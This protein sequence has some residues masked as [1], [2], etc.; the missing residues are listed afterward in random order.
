MFF[1]TN[2]IQTH[3]YTTETSSG[4]KQKYGHLTHV[5]IDEMFGLVRDV[6]AEI[7]SH[8]AMPSRIVLPVKLLLHV[9]CYVFLY[10]ILVQSLSGD[11]YGI[12][13]H[14]LLHVGVLNHYVTAVCHSTTYKK[15]TMS[16]ALAC[17]LLKNILTY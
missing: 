1:K 6:A 7:T 4:F 13:L 14:A 12:F 17:L 15:V 3:W 5:E 8:N 11:V 9:S 2:S 10:I 16:S